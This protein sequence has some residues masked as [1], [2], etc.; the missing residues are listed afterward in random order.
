MR[1]LIFTLIVFAM[2]SPF[3][4][5][6][7]MSQ[8]APPE[9]VAG[10][11]TPK[12][13]DSI[14]IVVDFAHDPAIDSGQLSTFLGS[15][16]KTFG[17]AIVLKSGQTI[18]IS[19]LKAGG[20]TSDVFVI[21]APTKSYSPSELTAVEE[22][23]HKGHSL[24]LLGTSNTS[25]MSVMRSFSRYAGFF[26]SSAIDAGIVSVSEFS[27]PGFPATD[28]VSQ[29]L[30]PSGAVIAQN[31]TWPSGIREVFPIAGSAAQPVAVVA[32][33]TRHARILGIAVGDAFNDS[34]MAPLDDFVLQISPI[35]EN[36]R[37]IRQA[38]EWLGGSTGLLRMTNVWTDKDG[39]AFLP[40]EIIHGNVTVTSWENTTLTGLRVSLILER[41][42][43]ILASSELVGNNSSFKGLVDTTGM[44]VC[45]FDIQLRAE[46]RG[47]YV[48]VTEAGRAFI[49]RA[50]H[51][52]GQ[53][54]MALLAM[55][56]AALVLTT[57][58]IGLAYRYYWMLPQESLPS[59]AGPE[60]I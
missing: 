51:L 23:L 26:F 12:A 2:I 55:A 13:V 53:V 30:A 21:V 20:S 19:T 5:Q 11:K 40:G 18:S 9:I 50:P 8:V 46:R 49:E 29:I 27:S 25:T 34:F 35:V 42:G 52:P 60:E 56:V 14:N 33:L 28:G 39:A 59:K 57:V 37:F 15:L 41:T 44:P 6:V 32:E 22:Y 48:L 17:T 16:N 1:Q 58:S 7:A 38:L 36:E 47:Y 31:S 3:L 24:L 45:N 54:N 10:P 4:A 43:F